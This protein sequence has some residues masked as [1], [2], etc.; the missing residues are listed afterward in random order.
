MM[1]PHRVLLRMRDVG[2]ALEAAGAYRKRLNRIGL[3]KFI[4]LQDAISTLYEVLPPV[5]AYQ[6]YK[7]GPYDPAVQNAVDSL[8]FRGFVR[9]F[10][11]E[12]DPDGHV[13]ATYAMSE[14]GSLM[15]GK[16]AQAEPFRARWEAAADV[17]VKIERLGWHRLRELAYAEPTYAMARIRGFGQSLRPED[18]LAN[19]SASLL[20]LVR[21]TA[22]RGFEGAYPSRGQLLELFFRYLDTYA[23]IAHRKSTSLPTLPGEATP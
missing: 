22:G 13:S 10:G 6:T 19:S 4:Y 9:V 14:A 11:V 17:A 20:E 2:F 16:L 18:R 3:Q 8:A 1:D 21:M 23:A 12:R 5:E 15:V 7:H